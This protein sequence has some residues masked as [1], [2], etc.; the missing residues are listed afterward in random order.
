MKSKFFERIK[1]AVIER[2]VE[3]VYNSGINLY[4]SNA[5]I[6][7]PFACD[8]FVDTK[9]SNGKML[10]LIIEYKLDE[11]LVSR[12]ARAKVIIQV[13]YYLKRFENDGMILP[14]VCLIGDKNECF[15]FHTNDIIKFLD[16]ETDWTFAPSSAHIK[17]PDFVMEIASDE[18]FN[19]FIFNIDENFSFK[20]VAEKIQDLAENVQRFVHITEHNIAKI[21][22]TF[23]GRVIK[24]PK[25]Y[26]SKELVEKS[27]KYRG[28]FNEEEPRYQINNFDAGWYQIKGMLK[29]YM[30]NE[31]KEFNE[32]YKSFANRLKPLVYELGFLKK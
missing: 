26:S 10:K 25:K 3:D 15:V 14:N 32:M 18:N 31:L 2:E 17:N 13:L 16:K 24:N 9:T 5:E 1:S 8:G 4:F 11:I 20:N 22:E 7:H 6:T 12:V 21:Y 28:M 23:L 29:A 30:P 27:F 19:P